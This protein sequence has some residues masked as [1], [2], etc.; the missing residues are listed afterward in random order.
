MATSRK[1]PSYSGPGTRAALDPL[2]AKA[3]DLVNMSTAGIQTAANAGNPAAKRLVDAANK[4][5]R[6]LSEFKRTYGK[7]QLGTS[8]YPKLKQAAEDATNLGRKVGRRTAEGAR[9]VGR[10]ARNLLDRLESP[11]P[12]GGV[13][14]GLTGGTLSGRRR[15]VGDGYNPGVV[16]AAAKGGAVKS[17]KKSSRKKSK[18]DGIAKK[19]FT[20]APHRS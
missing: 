8:A 17:P 18:I 2:S 15:P 10:S 11:I 16:I 14:G 20:K 12:T 1:K 13:R 7:G 5:G 9:G 3:S 4:A 6:R 19:G